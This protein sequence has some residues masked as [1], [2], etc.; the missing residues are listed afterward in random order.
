MRAA[1]MLGVALLFFAWT[2]LFT[3]S[4]A[5][6]YFA[7]DSFAPFWKQGIQPINPGPAGQPVKAGEPQ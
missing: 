7:E 5:Y 3:V 1:K 4:Q 6:A 2:A